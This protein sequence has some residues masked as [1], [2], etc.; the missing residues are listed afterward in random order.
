MLVNIVRIACPRNQ[1]SSRRT[2]EPDVID[3]ETIRLHGFDKVWEKMSPVK[4]ALCWGSDNITGQT[5]R[6]LLGVIH[7]PPTL[8]EIKKT[9]TVYYT[10]TGKRPTCHRAVWLEG[11]DKT[12]KTVDC[13]SGTTTGSRLP[14]SRPKCWGGDMT[15]L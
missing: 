11:L 14:K 13:I 15:G 5:V 2:L 4:S 9:I 8:D 7:P 1:E 3:A 6:E 12:S 10:R